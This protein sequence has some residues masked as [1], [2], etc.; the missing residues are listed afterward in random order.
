MTALLFTAFVG[1]AALA[2]DLGLVLTQQRFNQ[3]GADAAALAAA[4]LLAEAASPLDVSG[5]LYLAV[6]DADV[7][8]EVRRYAGLDAA[9]TSAVPSGANRSAGLIG[10]TALAVSLEYA[11]AGAWC[12][13]PSGP[14]PPRSPPTPPCALPL[15][16]GI[17]HPPLPIAAQP[18]RVRVTVSS[19]T[20]AV[21]AGAIG[22]GDSAPSPST[23][24]A[25]PACV[26]PTGTVGNT[27]CAHAIAVI[28]GS[29]ARSSPAP[30]LP[31]TTADCQ[32]TAP[33]GGALFQLWGS[34][35]SGCGVDLGSWKNFLDFTTE[36]RWCNTLKGSTDPDY[37]YTNL[38]PPGAQI[39][40]GPCA[41]ELPDQ[42]WSRIGYA[43]D[44]RWPGSNDV[45]VDLRYWIAAG[46]GGTL[47]AGYVDGNR[48][49]T[50][51][52][53]KSSPA[54]DL[55]QNVAAGFYCGASG[56]TATSCDT[57]L[58][59][60][61]TYFFAKNQSGFHDVCPDRWGRS[62]GAGCREAAVVTWIQPEWVVGLQTGGTGWTSG[63]SGGPARVRAARLLTFRLYCDHTTGGL[64]TL[65][66]KSIV[67]SA[68]N[69]SVWGRAVSPLIVGACPSCATG[70][71]LYGN[72]VTLE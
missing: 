20:G 71:S 16:A 49:P 33:T 28:A 59:P 23:A 7:Y 38:L 51:M 56:V 45:N 42:S 55:G 29:T 60:A 25:V 66:P 8:R 30:I 12:Y 3:N 57:A 44:P 58:N 15:V 21:F 46:F 2:V 36:T 1:L 43:P 64:C 40:G 34:N 24:A 61:G 19:T 17:A 37:R 72:K 9:T 47:R 11:A 10:R 48:F 52:D 32:I 62:Y 26:K 63:G 31:V 4:R 41:A 65:P 39:P 50:Y 14:A 67:G 13:S 54:G 70:P 35:P 53:L 6:P 5:G 18:Y 69:A 27:T 68:A 22:S